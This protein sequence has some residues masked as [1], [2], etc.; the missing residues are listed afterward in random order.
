MAKKV[1]FNGIELSLP[2]YDKNALS[3]FDYL[4]KIISRL[5]S[6]LNK[7]DG[8]FELSINVDFVED[9]PPKHKIIDDGTSTKKS[10]QKVSKILKETAEKENDHGAGSVKVNLVVNDK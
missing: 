3:I 2:K 8:N 10:K 7:K 6:G 5:E 4:D 9:K 1:T